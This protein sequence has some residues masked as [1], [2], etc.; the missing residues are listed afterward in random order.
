MPYISR[1][2]AYVLTICL[3]AVVAGFTRWRMNMSW[4]NYDGPAVGTTIAGDKDAPPTRWWN[5]W[6]L[7]LFGWKT[8]TVFEVSREDAMRGY[9]VGYIDF[10]ENA[11]VEVETSYDRH[12]R[13]KNGYED[14][15]FFAVNSEG[16]ELRLK[17]VS[18]TTVD[19][20]IYADAPLH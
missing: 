20:S 4:N 7:A 10:D 11:K 12:F 17:V 15:A 8:V 18:R 2:K 19:N 5:R 13:M 1:R 3:A 16:K 9:S 14:C 6:Y